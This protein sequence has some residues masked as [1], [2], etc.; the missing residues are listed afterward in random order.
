MT[1]L[2]ASSFLEMRLIVVIAGVI[3]AVRFVLLE[4]SLKFQSDE[5]DLLVIYVNPLFGV[6][7]FFYKL[8]HQFS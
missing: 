5:P 2:H 1:S 7:G 8:R 4:Q 3:G 6:F